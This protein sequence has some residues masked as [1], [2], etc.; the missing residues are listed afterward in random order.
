MSK[1]AI[2]IV[3]DYLIGE[4]ELDPAHR[5]EWGYAT[6]THIREKCELAKLSQDDAEVVRNA[7]LGHV[8]G[9]HDMSAR[10]L[11]DL[12]EFWVRLE[13]VRPSDAQFKEVVLEVIKYETYAFNRA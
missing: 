13:A 3:L 10:E 5:P 1:S 12:F 8:L 11:I 4:W 6:L 2:N 7:F 9:I